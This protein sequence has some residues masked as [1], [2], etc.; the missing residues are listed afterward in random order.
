MLSALQANLFAA[1][2][3]AQAMSR[4]RTLHHALARTTRRGTPANAVLATGGIVLLLLLLLPDVA[5]AGAASSLIFL[6][7]FALAHLIN[8]LMRQRSGRAFPFQVPAFPL[9]PAVGLVSCL[10]LAIFQGLTVPA[11]GVI[12][13]VWISIGGGLFLTLFARRAAVVDA[14]AEA[15]DPELLRLRGRTHRQPG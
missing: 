7:T 1:S 3:V 6:F 9:V 13:A 14:A 11:A 15:L 8:V 10:G 5:V 2:R 12:T 4:D